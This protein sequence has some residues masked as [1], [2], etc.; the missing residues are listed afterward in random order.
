MAFVTGVE[1]A[2]AKSVEWVEATAFA[3]GGGMS[4]LNVLPWRV[5]S[6]ETGL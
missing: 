2:L 3:S 1:T 4:Y 6:E 5:V